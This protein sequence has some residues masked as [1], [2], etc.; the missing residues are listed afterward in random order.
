MKTYQPGTCEDRILTV[1]K[2]GGEHIVTIKLKDSDTEYI[3]L[4]PEGGKVILFYFILNF[5]LTLSLFLRVSIDV[6]V[7]LTT[8]H[9]F[10]YYRWAAFR[11]V[12]ND[13]EK[14]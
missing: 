8:P 11:Q 5:F 10:R 13:A 4:P 14:A 12:V 7:Q 2:S 9:L 1:T 3:E 6:S